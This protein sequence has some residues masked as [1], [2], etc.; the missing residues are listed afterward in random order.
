MASG[1]RQDR[2]NDRFLRW[3]PER[4]AYWLTREKNIAVRSFFFNFARRKPERLARMLRSMLRD[5][6]GPDYRPEHFEPPYDPWRQRLCLVPEGDLFEAI[7][8]GT[9][10]IVTDPVRTFT[11]RGI[12]LESDEFLPADVVITATGLRL[13]MAGKVAVSVDG[14]PVDFAQHFFYRGAMFSNLPNLSVVFGYLNASWTLR[15]DN[16]AAFVARILAHMAHTGT[17][18]AVP[19]LAPADEP[20]VVEPFDYSSGYLQRARDLMPKSGAELP[21]RLGHDYHADRRDFRTRPVADGVLRFTNPPARTAARN[22][23]QAA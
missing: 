18:I 8:R 4:W 9:A 6:L 5:Q 3:L 13:V 22:M 19:E 14:I 10:Q 23:E 16:T 17:R 11:E 21:W 12:I 15:A 1:P 20:A 7:K 2:W